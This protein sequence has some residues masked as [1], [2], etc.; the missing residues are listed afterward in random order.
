MRSYHNIQPISRNPRAKDPEPRVTAQV[1]R[2]PSSLISR[3]SSVVRP[4]SSAPATTP[5]LTLVEGYPS[6]DPLQSP[7]SYQEKC[8]ANAWPQRPIT[9]L[10]FSFDPNT[11]I[12]KCPF[13][14]K[15]G[16]KTNPM[17]PQKSLSFLLPPA[18]APEIHICREKKEEKE[19]LYYS[20]RAK[21]VIR[22]NDQKVTR[23][24]PLSSLYNDA[25]LY[26]TK[27]YENG[28]PA[29][30]RKTNPIRTQSNPI[31]GPR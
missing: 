13:R 15:F 29:A 12:K 24:H 23:K 19:F 10:Y 27:C 26:P 8:Q 16:P 9:T 30:G 31:Q 3:L 2:P 21:T 14:R 20:F 6:R 25:N 18:H 5:V 28:H 1:V 22:A 7:V 11:V 17:T 4:P